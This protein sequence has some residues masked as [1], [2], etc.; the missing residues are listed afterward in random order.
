MR[1]YDMEPQCILTM[2]ILE[3]TDGVEK[4]SKSLDNFIALTD[5]AGTM[6]GKTMSIPDTLL[7]RYLQLACFAPSEEISRIEGGLSDG[8]LHPRNVKVDIAKRIVTRY[9][10]QEAADAAFAEFEKVFVNKDV[11]DEIP[12][13]PIPSGA[14]TIKLVDALVGSGS[15]AS[16]SEARRLIQQG[17]VKIEGDQVKDINAELDAS[18]QPIVRAGKLKWFRL[19]P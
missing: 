4:M 12:D 11:P 2:P 1:A 8:S 18:T 3:G 7:M 13:W 9:H 5:D 16:K 6:F 14:T 10:D 15:V 17:G 19:T